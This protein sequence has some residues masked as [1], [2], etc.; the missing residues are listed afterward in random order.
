MVLE[1]T[2]RVARS[3]I[4]RVLVLGVAWSVASAAASLA[5]AGAKMVEGVVNL[6]TAPPEMLSALPGIGPAKAVGILAYR[7]RHPFR[8]VDEL[9]RV[10]GIGRRMVQAMRSHLA[11]SGPSTA[12]ALLSLPAG[13]AGPAGAATPVVAQLPVRAAAPLCR[14]PPLPPP[15][16]AVARAI[17]AAQARSTRVIANHCLP[18]P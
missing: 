2:R 10:K 5:W 9:V 17:R 6:N 11:V 4:S 12:R 7:A 18:P 8:T 16:A 15:P 1:G 13:A 14:A 3:R